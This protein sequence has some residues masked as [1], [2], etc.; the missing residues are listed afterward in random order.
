M[1]EGEGR[2]PLSTERRHRF[3]VK[4]AAREGYQSV[5]QQKR[6]TT[7]GGNGPG[8]VQHQR[9]GYPAESLGNEILQ[10][11]TT[12]F[13]MPCIPSGF[14]AIAGREI[15][16]LFDPVRLATTGTVRAPHLSMSA[17]G[18]VPV[19]PK[20]GETMREAADREVLAARTTAGLWTHPPSARSTSRGPMQPNS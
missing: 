14:G 13:R 7:P 15:G 1:G 2:K 11:G 17:S 9:P 4:L 3:D 16:D 8:D 6:H 18:C 5:E 20:D 19:H 12:T 10:V